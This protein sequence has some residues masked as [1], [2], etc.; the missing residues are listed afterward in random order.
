MSAT[1]AEKL[2]EEVIHANLTEVRRQR[3][4]LQK[5]VDELR[6]LVQEFPGKLTNARLDAKEGVPTKYNYARAPRRRAPTGSD[7]NAAEKEKTWGEIAAL[8]KQLN[9]EIVQKRQSPRG[10]AEDRFAC[11]MFGGRIATFVDARGRPIN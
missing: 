6:A 2:N 5:Q 9:R 8:Q 7:M 3:D 11:A 4:V 1:T 10:S